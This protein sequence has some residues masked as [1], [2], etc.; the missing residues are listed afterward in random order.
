MAACNIPTHYNEYFCESPQ[1]SYE[2]VKNVHT[3]FDGLNM[4]GN[5]V[6]KRQTTVYA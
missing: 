4:E 6:C 5:Y 1:P 3:V 2:N